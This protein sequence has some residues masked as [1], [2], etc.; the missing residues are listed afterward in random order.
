MTDHHAL[1]A[2]VIA[3][4]MSDLIVEEREQL[5]TDIH[6]VH[7]ATHVAGDTGVFATD[8]SLAVDRDGA[9]RSG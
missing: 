4:V 6:Q 7:F 1:I 5:R 9:V 2:Q 3:K 8:D